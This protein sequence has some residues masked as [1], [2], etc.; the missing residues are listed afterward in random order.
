MYFPSFALCMLCRHGDRKI[1]QFKK[2]YGF[3]K[4]FLNYAI[5]ARD[6]NRIESLFFEAPNP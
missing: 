6:K 1:V 2:I 5:P 3:P 4:L